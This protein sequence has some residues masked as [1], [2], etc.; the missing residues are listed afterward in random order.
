MAVYT[1]GALS[2][3]FYLCVTI[4]QIVY[5]TPKPRQGWVMAFLSTDEVRLTKTAIPVASIGLVIDV[6]LLVIPSLAVYNLQLT[7]I[8]K[9]GL[10]LMFSTGSG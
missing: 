6:F 1:G 3:I 7:K 5:S 8:R 2:T 9:I 10:M 4:L